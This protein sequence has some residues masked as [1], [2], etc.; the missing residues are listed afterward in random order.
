M[1]G[2]SETGDIV[3]E[4]FWNGEGDSRHTFWPRQETYLYLLKFTKV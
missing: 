3:R 2:D 1:C 4:K